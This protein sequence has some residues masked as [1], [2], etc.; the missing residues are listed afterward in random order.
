MSPDL[1]VCIVFGRARRFDVLKPREW[2]CGSTSL[3]DLCLPVPGRVNFPFF[4]PSGL[5]LTYF[6]EKFSLLLS[7]STFRLYGSGHSD[8][9]ILE[10]S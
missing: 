2:G 3:L 10:S 9:D 7:F 1:G 5:D 8:R 6:Q 4:E